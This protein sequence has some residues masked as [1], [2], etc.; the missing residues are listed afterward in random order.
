MLVHECARSLPLRCGVS[1][2]GLGAGPRPTRSDGTGLFPDRFVR[3]PA[4]GLELLC[5]RF[6]GA[7]V[8]LRLAFLFAAGLL[9]QSESWTRGLILRRTHGTADPQ[10][11]PVGRAGLV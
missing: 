8:V 4:L 5:Q 2:T 11:Q 7:V 10:H 3:I 9:G 6:D 1:N